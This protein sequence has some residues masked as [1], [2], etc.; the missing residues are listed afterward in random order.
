MLP[1]I[2]LEFLPLDVV[3]NARRLWVLRLPS[4]AL[5]AG[6]DPAPLVRA[7]DRDGNPVGSAVTPVHAD[8]GLLYFLQNTLR[9]APAPGRGFAVADTHVRSRIRTFDEE[10]APVG[11]IPVLYKAEG[12]APL[13][14][15][16]AGLDDA[17]LQGVARTATDLTWDPRRAIYWVLGGYSDRNPDGSWVSGRE[18]Y[19]YD[20]EGT[21]RGS[22]ILPFSALRL[23]A[24]ADGTIWLLDG[25]G[26]VH[27]MRVRDPEAP[28]AGSATGGG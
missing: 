5:V 21:Y 26:R 11:T 10:G 22:L 16:P 25:E 24:S 6:S 17:S 28:R 20:R 15:L 18:L 14:R 2:A 27:R 19:R 12:W 3:G 1:G 4:P 8:I 9:M 23:A 13:G 7:F